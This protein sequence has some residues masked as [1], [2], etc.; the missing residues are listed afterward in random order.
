VDHLAAALRYASQGIPVFPLAPRS[1]FPLI[2]AADGGHGLHDATTD[3]AQIQAWWTAHPTGNIG[4]RT[5]VVFDVI[6]LDSEAAVDAL[7]SARAG[8][9][10]INGPVVATAK[11][12]HYFVLPTGL[13]NRAGVLPGVDFRGAGGYVAAPPSVHPS[14]VRYRWIIHDRLGQAPSWL[15]ELIGPRR[16]RTVNSCKEAAP[17]EPG[18]ARAYGRAALRDELRQLADAQPGERN[19]RLN[20]AA[21]S[22]GRLIA[23]RALDETE[24]VAALK[25]AGLALG[26]GTREVE[27]TIASG[28]NAGLGRSRPMT[29]QPDGLS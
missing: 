3:A 10:R 28:I 1:K 25:T 14:G 29:I 26:L 7:E 4:L 20:L 24:T 5:G 27:R 18:R 13:G 2:A 9:E 21:W 19:S 6:D 23:M 16:E 17:I 11:G 12:F 15:L 8:R 22:L